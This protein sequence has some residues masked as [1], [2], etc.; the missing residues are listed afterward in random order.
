MPARISSARAC[1]T[2][3]CKVK[4]SGKRGLIRRLGRFGLGADRG[5]FLEPFGRVEVGQRFDELTEIAVEDAVELMRREVDAVI[6][7]A[8]LRKVVRA[9]LLGPVAGSD[10]AAALLRNRVLLLA[11]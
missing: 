10:L 9:D 2:R 7:D 3:A 11:H 8:A 4:L 6:G 5:R 1:C